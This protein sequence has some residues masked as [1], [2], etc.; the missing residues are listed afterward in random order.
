MGITPIAHRAK[1]LIGRNVAHWLR[2]MK[3]QKSGW[4]GLNLKNRLNC[5]GGKKIQCFLDNLQQMDGLLQTFDEAIF[6]AMTERITV[7][8]KRNFAVTFRDGREVHVESSE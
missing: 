3:M 6:K 8:S 5:S 2:N 4:S 1:R 7:L